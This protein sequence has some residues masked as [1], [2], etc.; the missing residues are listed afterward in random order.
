MVDQRRRER[1]EPPCKGPA[2]G[3][4]GKDCGEENLGICELRAEQAGSRAAGSLRDSRVSDP[5]V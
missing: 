2:D 1:A 3:R 4:G 5:R